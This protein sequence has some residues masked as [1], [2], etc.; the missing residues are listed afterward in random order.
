MSTHRRTWQKVEQRAAALFGARRQVCSGS[1]GRSDLTKSD[2]T[3]P[4]L[5]IETKLRERSAARSLLDAT[6]E[7]ARKERKTAVLM[8]ADKGRPGMLVCCHS[9][10]LERLAVAYCAAHASDELM[11]KIRAAYDRLHGFDD[12]GTD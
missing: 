4:S 2:S 11:A 9:D 8:L 7:L 3:H 1:S 10:D 5:F 6:R 12:G